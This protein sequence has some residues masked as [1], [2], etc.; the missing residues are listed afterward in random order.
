MINEAREAKEETEMSMQGKAWR[1]FGLIVAA[2]AVVFLILW[3][4]GV[5]DFGGGGEELD[6][7]T[8]IMPFIPNTEWLGFYAA[9]TEGYYADEGIEVE[10]TY[11]SEGGYGAI[12]QVVADQAEFGYAAGESVILARAEG[13]PVVAVYQPD[14]NGQFSL[15]TLQGSGIAGPEDLAGG[16]IAITG[17]GGPVDIAA[18][19]MLSASGVDLDTVTF[20]PVGSGLISALTEREADAIAT[21]IFH[22]VLL[23]SMDVDYNVWYARD[24]AGNYGTSSVVTTDEIADSNP[25]LVERFVRATHLGW[26]YAMEHPEE[27]TDK[28]IE[29]FNPEG[30]DYR[31][32]ELEFWERI[33]EEVFLAGEPGFGE[34]V[35][36]LWETAMQVLVDTGSIDSPI[37]VTAAY[38]TQ[39]GP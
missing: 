4:T 8:A 35:P 15:I 1:A 20:V 25:D 17:A 11:T 24:Y 10:M 2:A 13:S 33:T 34:I 6:Q 39:F 22:E 29:Q 27:M 18:R 38:R 37:D 36:S 32:V 9:I 16:T 7:V 31:A 3:A 5:I 14:R 19:A 12:K 23:D 21:L 30:A 28:Y 26:V